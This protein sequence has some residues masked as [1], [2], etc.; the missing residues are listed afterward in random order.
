[1]ASCQG[2]KLRNGRPYEIVKLAKN[3]T[4][5]PCPEHA[6]PS[7]ASDY[8]VDLMPENLGTDGRVLK[9]EMQA[10]KEVVGVLLEAHPEAAQTKDEARSH[11][12]R[13]H[14]PW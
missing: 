5:R 6:D 12:T 2:R 9:A 10:S 7:D 13:C 11:T 1:M 4:I 8:L 3:V 14:S